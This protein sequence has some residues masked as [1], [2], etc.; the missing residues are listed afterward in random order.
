MKLL[1]ILCVPFTAQHARPGGSSAAA[2][3]LVAGMVWSAQ[4]RLLSQVTFPMPLSCH[5][6]GLGP[7]PTPMPP[8][9]PR[10]TPGTAMHAMGDD[11]LQP[12]QPHG[13]EQQTYL[14]YVPAIQIA[15][16][17]KKCTHTKSSAPQTS[18]GNHKDHRSTSTRGPHSLALDTNRFIPSYKG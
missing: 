18:P 7:A 8:S 4:P 11:S 5:S 15:K 2:S 12:I 3:N 17:I 14:P 10:C 13:G 16:D 9:A 6:T 1:V